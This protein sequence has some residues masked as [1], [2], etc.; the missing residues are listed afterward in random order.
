VPEFDGNGN[1]VAI[2][3]LTLENEGWE[4]DPSVQGPAESGFT[5]P[6]S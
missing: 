4:R 1:A 6:S 3:S 5:L 2:E